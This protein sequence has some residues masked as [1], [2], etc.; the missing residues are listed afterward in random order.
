M[1]P[2]AFNLTT[3]SDGVNWP[4]MHDEFSL[5]SAFSE[6]Q[7]ACFDCCCYLFLSMNVDHYFCYALAGEANIVGALWVFAQNVSCDILI[8]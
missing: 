2:Q 4:R 3:V 6:M 1:V 7:F 5:S 8:G